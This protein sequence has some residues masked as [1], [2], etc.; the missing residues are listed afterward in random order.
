MAQN[1]GSREKHGTLLASFLDILFNRWNYDKMIKAEAD[2]S[3]VN[4]R[5]TQR[6]AFASGDLEKHILKVRQGKK[7]Q[8]LLILQTSYFLRTESICFGGSE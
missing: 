2:K 8:D 3:M 7:W 4:L 6:L 5:S 1:S